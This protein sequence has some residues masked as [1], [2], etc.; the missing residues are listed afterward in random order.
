MKIDTESYV[1]KE[2]RCR[3]KSEGG[4]RVESKSCGSVVSKRAFRCV[5][6]IVGRSV[7]K[8]E[9]ERKQKPG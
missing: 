3:S 1:A 6:E 7:R 8:C 9:E 2:R 5:S 4:N